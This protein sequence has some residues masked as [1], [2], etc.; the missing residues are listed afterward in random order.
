MKKPNTTTKTKTGY[1]Y[2]VLLFFFILLMATFRAMISRETRIAIHKDHHPSCIDRTI[3][4]KIQ[5]PERVKKR[6]FFLNKD[7]K[8]TIVL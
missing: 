2:A 3:P 1:P 8:L 7:G 5:K 4:N 6:G